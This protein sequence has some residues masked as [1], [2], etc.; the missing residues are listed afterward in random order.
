MTNISIT[1][2]Y[3]SVLT[4]WI[5]RQLLE[6][7]LPERFC[8]LRT[9]PNEKYCCKY[10]RLGIIWQLWCHCNPDH[11]K[12]SSLSNTFV[13]RRMRNFL[14]GGAVNHLPK[15]FS[16]VA[17]IFFLY[18]RKE[19][20]AIRCNHIGCTCIWRWLDTVTVFQGQYLPVLSITTLPQTNIG[21]IATT[22]L[23]DKDENFSWS[24]MQWHWSCHSNEVTLLPILLAAIFLS[25]GNCSCKIAHGSFFLK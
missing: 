2:S 15:K 20:R 24:G 21:K 11:D 17:P 16:Q 6:E 3:S 7:E 10:D 14:L 8:K 22:V 19:T 1:L 13:H 25:T 12:F 9:V 18:S 23:L 4:S 5:S